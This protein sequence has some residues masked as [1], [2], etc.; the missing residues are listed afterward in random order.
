VKTNLPFISFSSRRNGVAVKRAC[1][2]SPKRSNR[3]LQVR[4]GAWWASSTSTRSNR[5][6]GG[7]GITPSRGLTLGTV[8]TTTSYCLRSSHASSDPIVPSVAK[9]LGQA[10][11]SGKA[12][13]FFKST[14][15]LKFSAICSRTRRL[16][17]KIKTRSARN[18]NATAIRTVVLPEPVGMVTMAGCFEL[19]K[20]A[21]TAC[22]AATCATLK[23]G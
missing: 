14:R 9:T 22:A 17:V 7:A 12:S 11:S 21:E 13:I 4:A 19:K 1:F 2:A 6:P 20:W 15:A 16:G 5:S 3:R 23:P 18:K 8:A 10:R